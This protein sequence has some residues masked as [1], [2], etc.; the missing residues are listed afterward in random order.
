MAPSGPLTVI[1]SNGEQATAE[2][3]PVHGDTRAVVRLASGRIVVVPVDALE[4]QDEHTYRLSLPFTAL[5]LEQDDQLRM[6][7]EQTQVIPMS[8]IAAAN[9]TAIVGAATTDTGV[10]AS[11]ETAESAVIPVIEEHVS[12]SKRVVETGGVRIRKV[13]QERPQ[14]FQ[15]S[16]LREQVDVERVPVN[17]MVEGDP[18]GVRQEGDTLIIPLV[19]EV[20]VVERRL[21]LREELRVTRRQETLD[22][23]QTVLVRSEDV[24]IERFDGEG[25]TV[26]QDDR[27]VAPA[28]EGVATTNL[29]AATNNT[30]PTV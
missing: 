12:V 17:R 8:S 21:L 15:E 9:A 16:L 19:E 28:A 26:P 13:V 6:D 7:P 23:A 1:D 18:P 22:Q 24:V 10:S 3:R 30:P 25:N 29:P 4:Q 5:E 2:T 14:T 20:L 11:V 27:V